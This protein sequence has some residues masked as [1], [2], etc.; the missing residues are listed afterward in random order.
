[1]ALDN[2]LYLSKALV[3]ADRKP[4]AKECGHNV[5]NTFISKLRRMMEIEP[6]DAAEQNVVAEAREIAA[7]AGLK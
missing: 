7:K 2:L 3:A 5:E 6:R 4:E 1:M